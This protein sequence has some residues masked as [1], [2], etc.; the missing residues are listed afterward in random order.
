MDILELAGLGWKHAANLVSEEIYLKTDFDSTRPV[1][2]YGIINERCNVKCR[3][4]EYWKLKEYVEE[5]S[6]A[7]WQDALLSIKDFVG[8]FSINFSVGEPFLRK[9]FPDLLAWCHA[10]G[11]K[12]GVTTNGSALNARVVARLVAARPFNVNISVDAA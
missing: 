4:C 9:D 12:A 8:R 10:N 1:T 2:F 5:M 7:E 3:Y 11:I 6:N